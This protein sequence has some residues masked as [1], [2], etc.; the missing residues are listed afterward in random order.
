MEQLKYHLR[1]GRH[2][3]QLYF[4]YSRALFVFFLIVLMRFRKFAF[5]VNSTRPHKAVAFSNLSILESVFKSLRFHIVFVWM[6]HVNESKC[7]RI[8]MKTHLK[9]W[10]F[11][12]LPSTLK[13]CNWWLLWLKTVV[14]VNC[15]QSV[16]FRK[17][18]E[19]GAFS[20]E[21]VLVWTDGFK[22]AWEMWIKNLSHDIGPSPRRRVIR[23]GTC[24]VSGYS[25]FEAFY[26]F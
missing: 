16:G 22:N 23:C 3:C 24:A 8:Q 10:Y 9:V 2:K 13:W 25:I 4:T 15:S 6:G 7:L 20:N 26:A 12:A 21:N 19:K 11:C 14:F 1:G 17:H 18:I 5:S